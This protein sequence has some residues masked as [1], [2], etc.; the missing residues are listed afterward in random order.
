MDIREILQSITF[1]ERIAEDE[2]DRLSS[3]FVETDQWRRIFNGEVDIVYGPKGSGKSAIYFLLLNRINELSA[4]NIALI[5]AENPRGA[6]AFKDLVEDPP[7]SE[8]EFRALWKMYLLT[9]VGNEVRRSGVRNEE[10]RLLVSHLEDADLL[11]P[12]ATTLSQRIRSVIQYVRSMAQLE[13]V[14]GGL[15]LDPQTGQPLGIIGKITLREPTADQRRAGLISADELFAN[16]DE[17]L[18]TEGLQVWLVLDRLDVAFAE[19]PELE[20]HALRALFRVYVDLLGFSCISLKIF[21]R[22]DI[23]RRITEA[24]FREAS[25]ITRSITITWDDP[26]LLNLIIRRALRNDPI[27]HR[28]QADPTAVISSMATQEE[29]FY[30]MFP[31]QVDRGSRKLTTLD[32]MLSR[33]RDGTKHTAP[34]ELIHL[35]DAIR[36]SQLRKMEIGEDE[37]TDGRLFSSSAIKSALPEVSKTRLEQTLF[38]EFPDL[39]QAVLALEGQKTQQEIGSLSTIWGSSQ[40]EARTRALRLVEIGFFEQ[41]GSMAEPTFWVPFLYRDALEMVQGAAD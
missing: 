31:K 40:D 30:K 32:W 2:G 35:L 1:G 23:W 26:S 37:P 7:T 36:G 21:L 18:R 15:Q 3:Y 10:A 39:K 13:S 6:P 24:G 19:S 9:L 34:R 11:D 5:A 14:E 22:D 27:L 38:A 17:A 25:H 28:Y 8:T 33:T 20:Q 4:R 12:G 41:R 16:A 29:L